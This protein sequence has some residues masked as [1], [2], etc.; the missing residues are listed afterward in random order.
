MAHDAGHDQVARQHFHRALDLVSVSGDRQLTAH[1][2]ASIG[3][4]AHHMGDPEGAIR[5]ARAGLDTLAGG[6]FCPDLEARLLAIE[7]RGLAALH[8]AAGSVRCLLL[9]EKALTADRGEPCSVWVSGFDEGALAGEA[10]RCMLQ[11]GQLTEAG[12]HADRVISLRPP[13]RP[14][15]RAF[16]MFVRANVLCA[17]RKP[18]EASAVGA[19]I[20]QATDSLSSHIVVQQFLDLRRA[21]GPYQSDASVAE[22]L[23]CLEPALRERLRVHESFPVGSQPTLVALGGPA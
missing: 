15:S 14:R 22:F 9:A 8:D 10:A 20:L 17:G 13:S 23:D 1:V 7:A 6:S 16:G 2:L 18:D 5:A 21:L 3:H 19:E 11:L 4:L 12:R